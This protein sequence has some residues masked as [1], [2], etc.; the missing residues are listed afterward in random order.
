MVAAYL[1]LDGSRRTR[2]TMLLFLSLAAVLSFLHLPWQELFWYPFG[3][4]TFVADFV[5]TGHGPEQVWSLLSGDE[6]KPR[7]HGF[8]HYRITLAPLLMALST[9]I[10]LF[11]RLF[12]PLTQRLS[13]L[14]TVG[15]HSLDIYILHLVLVGAVVVIDG[16]KRPFRDV[17]TITLCFLGITGMCYGYAAWKDQRNKRT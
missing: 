17:T 10:Y 16:H 12:T 2:A 13:P 9:G 11:F 6:A 5:G 8:Y 1:L 3:R 7:R 14:W 15:R 4:V